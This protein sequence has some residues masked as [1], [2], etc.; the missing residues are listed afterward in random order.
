VARDKEFN[1]IL[2]D[3]I[4]RLLVRGETLQQCLDSY[5]EYAAELEPLLQ[6][7]LATNEAVSVQP[8]PDFKARARYELNVLLQQ[9]KSKR[10]I[11]V[12]SWRPRW[13]VATAALLVVVL[14][15]GGSTAL[16]ADQIM[17]GNPLYPVKLAT[18]Q[19]GLTFTTSD[20]GKAELY[21]TLADR[22]VAELDYVISKGK[23]H[24][25]EPTTE[26][27]NGHLSMMTGLHL[28]EGSEIAPKKGPAGREQMGREGDVVFVP[29]NG[30]ARLRGL[31][32]RFSV[33][34]PTRL[35]SL[36]ERAPESAKPALQR[37][38]DMSNASYQQAL[39]DL[40]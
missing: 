24:W 34:H 31:L 7:A 10:R 40:D 1:N 20:I 15:T 19:V 28:G 18:E 36:L 29:G 37:A 26:R 30:R 9:E 27:L 38:I 11:P 17:P 23:P 2:D 22:R 14:L 13:A 21:A 33:N 5:P 35:Q 8:D 4:E 6:M 3:C 39:R 12:L 25:V 16:A 32:G